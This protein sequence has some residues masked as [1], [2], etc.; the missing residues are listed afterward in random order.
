MGLRS[1]GIIVRAHGSRWL[2]I[3]VALRLLHRCVE[4]DIRRTEQKLA[5]L[6]AGLVAILASLGQVAL[7]DLD[8]V[9]EIAHALA[10]LDWVEANR[11]AIEMQVDPPNSWCPKVLPALGALPDDDLSD[12]H[13]GSPLDDG[14]TA[15]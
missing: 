5:D 4:V 10:D 12:G 3:A 9:F 14:G 8:L 1:E 13:F 2:G 6:G 15:G 11:A 7:V